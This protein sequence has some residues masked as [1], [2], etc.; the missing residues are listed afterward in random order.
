MPF[1]GD[2]MHRL[3]NSVEAEVDVENLK[4][5]LSDANISLL[6]ELRILFAYLT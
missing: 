3:I 4:L 2:D 5:V 6:S 1:A